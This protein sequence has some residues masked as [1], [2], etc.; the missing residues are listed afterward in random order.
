MDRAAGNGLDSELY[1]VNVGLDISWEIRA[2][3]PLIQLEATP[4]RLEFRARLG[5]GRLLGPW[6]VEHAQVTFPAAPVA[7]HNAERRHLGRG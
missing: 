3:P 1:R 4:G 7:Q 6:S 5:L 2:W